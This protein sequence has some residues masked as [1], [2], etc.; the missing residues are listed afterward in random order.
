MTALREYLET[1]IEAE[2]GIIEERFKAQSHALALQ[3]R[4][5]EHRFNAQQEAL[6]LQAS[7]YAR[8]LEALNAAHERA[9]KMAEKIIGRDAYKA[10]QD[11]NTKDHEDFKHDLTVIQTRS[12]TLMTVWG[13]VVSIVSLAIG[14]IMHFL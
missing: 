7:E 6:R 10:D 8:R 1:K 11:R 9:D 14:I 2:R 5:V 3:E 13:V 12:L 4:E